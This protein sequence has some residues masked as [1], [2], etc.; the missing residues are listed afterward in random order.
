M[1]IFINGQEFS[2]YLSKDEASAW[3]RKNHGSTALTRA[4]P[5]TLSLMMSP[6]WHGIGCGR[7][8]AFVECEAFKDVKM[9]TQYCQR[10]DRK[11]KGAIHVFHEIKAKG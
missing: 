4:K 2:D 1:N 10:S 8:E 9:D 3:R 11:F 6:R 7:C 5:I